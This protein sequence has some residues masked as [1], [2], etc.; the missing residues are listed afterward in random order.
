M[1]NSEA[2]PFNYDDKF[3]YWPR[4]KKGQVYGP[5]EFQ[6][7]LW[8]ENMP[9]D[10]RRECAHRHDLDI[11][12][13]LGATRS[14]KTRAA[15]ARCAYVARRYHNARIFVGSL[16]FTH[17]EETV[18]EDWKSLF[19]MNGGEWNHPSVV[20]KPSR[21]HKRLKI[22]T[23][24]GK[25]ISTVSFV[26]LENYLRILGSEADIWHIEEPELLK[27]HSA[28][29]TIITRMSSAA[30]PF[31]QIILT[32]N[33]TADSLDW[34]IDWFRL[35][36]FEED[37]TGEKLPVGR[38]CTCQ[39]CVPCE[40]KNKLVL[41]HE[42]G[43]PECGSEKSTKCPGN[44]IFQRVIMSDA[45]MNPHLTDNYQRD[46]KAT[47]SKDTQ[48]SLVK[49]FVFRRRRGGI[50][51]NHLSGESVYV[52][53]KEIRPNEPVI[54][55]HDFNRMP[56]C[57]V[58][59]QTWEKDK[60]THIDALDEIIVPNSGPE[61]VA[62]EFIS[63]Y[64][65]IINGVVRIYGDPSG[66]TGNIKGKQLDRFR[67]LEKLLKDAGFQVDLKAYPTVYGRSKRFDSVNHM[68]KSLDNDG[69]QITRLHFNPQCKW[70]LLSAQKTVW[71]RGGTGEEEKEDH[72]FRDKWKTTDGPWPLTHPMAALGYYIVEEHP[73]IPDARKSPFFQ[74]L[75]TGRIIQ[76]TND[77][78]IETTLTSQD[79]DDIR[80][81]FD[82]EDDLELER[83]AR[84]QLDMDY[85]EPS[86]A[87]MFRKGGRWGLR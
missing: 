59:C 72:Y 3:R 26:N 84:D 39:Y 57:S 52:R 79:L 82:L 74:T 14:G 22:R 75:G 44:Q 48:T 18:I 21:S 20:R 33:P 23:A 29:E 63:R 54:W 40:Q 49:G 81:E 31:K 37:Y 38:P 4:P 78:L 69:S 80:D 43:C 55:T 62:Y 32:A 60:L 28:L 61:E 85:K 34:L 13:L 77:D 27:G 45:S 66:F 15:V 17:L 47:L 67:I 30:V 83:Q 68:F 8:I 56:M 53:D 87:D 46:L 9:V 11:P 25:G 12:L 41:Y 16:N 65:G 6:K 35:E 73:I 42:G 36:Q 51:A 19:S 7:K 50:Y 2:K 64:R 58:V 70:L 24:D 1:S 71:N 76:L 86:I 5:T 10:V